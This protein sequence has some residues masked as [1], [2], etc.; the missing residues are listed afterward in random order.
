MGDFIDFFRR[1]IWAQ[2]IALVAVAAFALSIV[3]DSVAFFSAPWLPGW[4]P[5]IL[6]ASLFYAGFVGLSFRLDR[7]VRSLKV[8]VDA[9]KANPIPRIIIDAPP[10]ERSRFGPAGTPTMTFREFTQYMRLTFWTSQNPGRSV[11]QELCDKLHLRVLG[12]WGRREKGGRLE[13]LDH[14]L[15]SGTTIDAEGNAATEGGDVVFHDVQL[16]RDQVRLTWELRRG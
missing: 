13:R 15:W 5:G 3:N 6:A 11:V 14:Q 9:L 8:E 12:S 7:T 16:D 10:E 2:I 1:H 4:A